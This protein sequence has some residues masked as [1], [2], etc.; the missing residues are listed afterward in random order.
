MHIF[1]QKNHLYYFCRKSNEHCPFI[2]PKGHGT[3]GFTFHPGSNAAQ[4]CGP[5]KGSVQRG[6]EGRPR[7]S[8]SLLYCCTISALCFLRMRRPGEMISMGGSRSTFSPIRFLLDLKINNYAMIYDFSSCS[9]TT[10]GN[11]NISET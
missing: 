1:N 2:N 4:K 11:I 8:V 7:A 6:A 5:S 10:P 3:C 9:R